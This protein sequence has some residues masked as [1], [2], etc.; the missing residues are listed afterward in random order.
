MKSR[1]TPPVALGSCVLLLLA[2]CGESPA[3]LTGNLTYTAE[4]D[5]A[6]LCD[7]E[8]AFTGVP[9]E[10]PCVDCDWAFTLAPEVV[11]D[12]SV[13]DCLHRAEYTLFG[14][15]G[16][17]VVL[18]AYAS[19]EEHYAKYIEYE[20]SS[21]DGY[22]GYYAYYYYDVADVLTAFYD[23]PYQS[24][25]VLGP[26]AYSSTSWSEAAVDWQVDVSGEST[27][28]DEPWGAACPTSATAFD[29]ADP[30]AGYVNEATFEC[31][32]AVV[33]DVWQV[34]GK[35]GER[36]EFTAELA[37]PDDI[38]ISQLA[39]AD[40]YGCWIQPPYSSRLAPCSYDSPLCSGVGVT[41]SSEGPVSVLVSYGCAN[42]DPAVPY[43]LVVAGPD[44]PAH[45]TRVA[46]HA[47]T[48]ATTWPD[49]TQRVRFS[50][51]ITP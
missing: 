8:L 7:L 36:W 10:G 21:Y 34:D 39:V 1:G 20:T 11:S 41:L 12:A 51:T 13:E 38:V 28:V 33:A 15:S 48:S 37:N 27:F 14:R 30:V 6:L 19:Y 17:P 2:S 4:M 45:A 24:T 23:E 32:G 9:F 47:A 43:R 50:G 16:V 35:P 42:G 5:G 25:T 31:T 26:G 44:G 29:L 46:E 22:D 40:A 18:A 49:V 3:G